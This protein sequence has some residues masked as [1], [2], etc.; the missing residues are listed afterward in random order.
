MP[1]KIFADIN[2]RALIPIWNDI[3]ETGIQRDGY[4]DILP[5]ALDKI[6]KV[7]GRKPDECRV[8][9]GDSNLLVCRA[10]TITHMARVSGKLRTIVRFKTK[11]V[12]SYLRQR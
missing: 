3:K 5:E 12:E 4:V 1:E 10:K 2:K 9:W 8:R 11:E 6:I 7:Y